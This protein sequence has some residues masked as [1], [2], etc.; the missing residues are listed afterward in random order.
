MIDKR[1]L[2]ALLRLTSAMVIFGTIG[3][4]VRHIPLPSSVIAFFR[5]LIGTAFLLL[6]M[7]VTKKPLLIDVIG[8]NLVK[9]CISGAA[10]GLNWILLFEAYRYTSVATA[11]LCYYLAPIFI[12]L[13]SP[14]VLSERLTRRKGLCILVAL[15]GMVFVSGVASGG[16]PGAQEIRGVLYGVGAAALYA[17]VVLINKRMSGIEALSR[18]VVQLGVSALVLAPYIMMTENVLVLLPQL[19]AVSLALLFVLAI[20]HTGMAY[21]LYFGSIRDLSAQTAALFSYID[22]V[23]AIF[24]SAFLLGEAMTVSSTIGAVMILGSAVVSELPG[25]SDS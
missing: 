20:V 13:V 18:T 9:L 22:P 24:L 7:R 14:I 23:V 8:R 15:G 4:F 16:L 19:S 10:I 25:K 3:V 2:S 17:S 6:V 12:M 1:T 21:A 5:G 11:T